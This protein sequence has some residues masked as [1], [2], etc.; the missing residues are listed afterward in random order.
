VVGID[1]T[2]ARSRQ[3][4]SVTLT[5]LELPESLRQSSVALL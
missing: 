2:V 3:Y 1:D 5:P 4:F